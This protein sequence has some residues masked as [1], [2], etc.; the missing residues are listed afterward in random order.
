M[1]SILV[2][3]QYPLVISSPC[4]L[5]HL[6]QSHISSQGCNMGCNKKYCYFL[7]LFVIYVFLYIYIQTD[8]QIIKHKRVH[9]YMHPFKSYLLLI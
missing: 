7:L 6:A 2:S 1:Q 4:H 3:N 8:T 9:T 5:I